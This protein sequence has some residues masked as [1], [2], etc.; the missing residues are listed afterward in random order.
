MENY[1]LVAYV[2]IVFMENTLLTYTMIVDPGKRKFLNAYTLIYRA[3]LKSN[4]PAVYY[5]L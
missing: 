4:Q 5:I 2:R 1:Q 3:H